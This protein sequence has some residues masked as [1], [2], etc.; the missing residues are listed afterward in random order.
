MVRMVRM[1]MMMMVVVVVVVVVV[2]MHAMGCALSILT[3]GDMPYADTDQ[4]RWDSFGDLMEPLTASLPFMV[5]R[6]PAIPPSD[7]SAAGGC[8]QSRDRE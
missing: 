5:S 1:V 7:T 3:A 2:V 8:R 4:S 6:G